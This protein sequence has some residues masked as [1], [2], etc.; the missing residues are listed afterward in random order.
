MKP[1]GIVSQFFLS[2]LVLACL[3]TAG[4]YGGNL[5][6]RLTINEN[7]DQLIS[8]LKKE[9]YV[10]EPKSRIRFKISPGESVRYIITPPFY[11]SGTAIGI[12]GDDSVQKMKVLAYTLDSR[13]DNSG[14]LFFGEDISNSYFFTTLSK[15]AYFYMIEITLIESQDKLPASIDFLYGFK[16]IQLSKEDPDLKEV[17]YDHSD[18]SNLFKDPTRMPREKPIPSDTGRNPCYSVDHGVTCVK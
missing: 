17:Y 15:R 2:T 13:D 14:T 4:M 8:K 11:L 3:I 5:Y 12:A 7:R 6:P 18:E 9:G 16:T 10:L 1:K